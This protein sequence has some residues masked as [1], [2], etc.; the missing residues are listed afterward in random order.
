LR[1]RLPR[2]RATMGL[3]PG[4]RFSVKVAAVSGST[5]GEAGSTSRERSPVRQYLL[6]LFVV[7]QSLAVGAFGV[8]P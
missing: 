6:I 8:H 3:D 1:S 5:L 4:Y 2:A 7:Q